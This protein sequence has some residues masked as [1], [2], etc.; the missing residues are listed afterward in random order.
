MKR[1][2]PVLGLLLVFV[3]NSHADE[4]ESL[5]A[6]GEKVQKLALICPAS[7][8]VMTRRKA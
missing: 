2:L 6:P 8:I 3:T 7:S 5:I 4:I 1:V